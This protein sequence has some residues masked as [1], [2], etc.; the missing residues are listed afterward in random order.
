VTARPARR[1]V[2]ALGGNASLGCV[3]PADA[4]RQRARVETVAGA[5]AGLAT[6]GELVVTHGNG[7]QVG[8][9]ALQAA[10]YRE[11]APYPLDV[12]DAES[13]GM[14]GYLLELALRNALGG[15]AVATLLTLVVVRADDPAFAHSTKP[16][17]REYGREEATRL[18]RERGWSQRTSTRTG[19]SSPR[20]NP[21]GSSSST[22]S[23]SCSAA[24]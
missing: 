7:P 9:L 14:I 24:A 2:V 8:L 6:E 5:L 1:R 15:S 3:E 4:E 11:V 17:G 12:L 10:A 20:P 16:I 22:P 23:S 21:T 13:G 19:G 18:A